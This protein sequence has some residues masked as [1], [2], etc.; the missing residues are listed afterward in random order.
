M[1]KLDGGNKRTFTVLF[2]K[3]T[4][5]KFFNGISSPATIFHRLAC[6]ALD[7]FL[8]LTK[9]P[10]ESDAMMMSNSPMAPPTAP[11]VTTKQTMLFVGCAW[12]NQQLPAVDCVHNSLFH[13]HAG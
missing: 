9:R 6:R 11:P 4:F 5:S 2:R 8:F 3:L 13:P 12:Q 1:V 7:I 10:M